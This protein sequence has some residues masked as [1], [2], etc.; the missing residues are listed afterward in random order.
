[1]AAVYVSKA[2]RNDLTAIRTYI[3]EDLSN[4]DAARRIIREL[5]GHIEGLTEMPERGKPLDAIL[6][7]HTEFRFLVC[8]NYRIF[9]LYDGD[10]VEIVRVL[11]T[12]QDYMRELFL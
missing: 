3:R 12:L 5:R 9:Y 10:K 6:S 7:V 4:P 11:H 8:E 2:A 1:V